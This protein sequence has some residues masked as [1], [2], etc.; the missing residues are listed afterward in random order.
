M[1]TESEASCSELCQQTAETFQKS[2]LRW[3]GKNG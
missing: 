3:S 1:A 2:Q